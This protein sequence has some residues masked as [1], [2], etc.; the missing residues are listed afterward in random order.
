M[1]GMLVQ[2]TAPRLSQ[3]YTVNPDP[4]SSSVMVRTL[5][6]VQIHCQNFLSP[7]EMLRDVP[8]GQGICFV[9]DAAL[10][11]MPGLQ[12]MEKLRRRDCFHP[13]IFTSARS[14][15]ELITNVMNRGAFGFIKRPFRSMEVIDMVQRALMQDQALSSYINAALDYRQRRYALSRRELT[16]LGLLEL[17]KSAREVGGELNLSVRTVEN[18]RARIFQKLQIS[19]GAQMIQRA[20]SLN[21]LR[22]Q[23]II[24]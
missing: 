13:V 12:L 18:H 15:P 19:Q 16:I 24:E 5:S 4:V 2:S 21:L 23:G 3:V 8:S 11:E 6:T 9:F 14:D 20:T 10:P 7:T 17:G 1:A 22:A